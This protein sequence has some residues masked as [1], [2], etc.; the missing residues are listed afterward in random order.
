MTSQR[1]RRT[2]GITTKVVSGHGDLYITVNFAD[3][4]QTP[5][6]VFV[7][8]GHP[9]KCN[10]AGTE[11]VARLISLSLQE[12]IP[13]E[14]I[15]RQLRGITCCPTFGNGGHPILSIPDAIAQVLEESL[16]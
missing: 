1:P 14:S 6:E 5:F 12:G 15:I 8:V 16:S 2:Q 11:I 10:Y 4:C 9:D 13:V 3:G 7:R